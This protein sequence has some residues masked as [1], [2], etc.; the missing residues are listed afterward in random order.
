[1]RLS[2][3]YPCVPGMAQLVLPAFDDIDGGIASPFPPSYGACLLLF[4]IH[5]P[6]AHRE[7][8]PPH[9][10]FQGPGHESP[11]CGVQVG[12]FEVGSL[13]SLL[14]LVV[15]GGII[16]CSADGEVPRC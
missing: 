3:A 15:V 5:Q 14:G 16:N 10:A 12:R 2:P 4:Q 9:P 8:L 7:D 11:T 6:P 13:G 1:M